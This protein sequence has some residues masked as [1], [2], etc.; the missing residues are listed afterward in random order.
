MQEDAFKLSNKVEE[1]SVVSLCV[2]NVGRQKCLPGYQW[3]P[4][5]RDHYLIH[6]V[7]SGKGIYRISDT[8]YTLQAGDAFLV[9]PYT[10][11]SYRADDRDPWTYDWVGFAGTDAGAILEATGFSGKQNLLRSASCGEELKAAIRRISDAYG[12]SFENVIHMTGELYLMLMLLVREAGSTSV[13]VADDSEQVRRAIDFI[14]S[15]YS[16]PLSVEDIAAY[17]GV[18]RSTLFRQFRALFNI[19]PKEYLDSY[20]IRRASWLLKHT[21]LTIGSVSVSVGYD[22]G[23]YFS[24]VFKKATGMTPSQYRS[25]YQDK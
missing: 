11:I 8:V 22:N 9:R 20:R 12:N 1:R 3:G 14:D 18:S 17:T 4:G 6:Y 16:Y 23:M 5:V 19:S 7:S 13:P 2:Y 24:K 15:R 25:I 21:S 10:A